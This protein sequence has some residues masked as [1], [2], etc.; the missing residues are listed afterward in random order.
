[1]NPFEQSSNVLVS[2]P[3]AIPPF[4]SEEIRALGFPV[5]A[6][7]EAGVETCGTLADCMRL[8]LCLRTAHRVLYQLVQFRATTPDELYARVSDLPWEDYIPP[9]GYLTV[10]SSVETDAIRDSRFANVRCKDAI[11]DRLR[12]RFGR[13]PDSGPLQS[14]AVVFLYWKGCQATLYLNTS[15]EPL[16]RRGYRKIPLGAPMQETLAAAVISATGWDRSSH[17]VNPMC[18]SG[19][20][21]IEAAWIGLN[22]APGLLRPNFAFM[23][24]NGFSDEAWQALRNAARRAAV[25]TLRGRLIATDVNPKA[26][27]SAQLNARTAGVEQY[28]EF[29]TCD[30]AETPV[31][32]GSGVVILNPEYGERMGELAALEPV[33]RGIGDYFKQRCL[34]YKGYVFTGNS[35]LA[36]RVGLR[37]RRRTVF[38]NSRIE[39]RLLEYELYGGT[40]R[41]FADQPVEPVMPG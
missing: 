40:R 26:I 18:G 24:L 15:G 13:R 31:P 32:E 35:D 41:Q 25:K 39:C 29:Q 8:N 5:R 10:D 1:M 21:A 20:L 11:V 23:H 22:R 34:G 12:R 9:D 27:Q 14:G 30:F 37:T 19:T 17:F 3:K 28:I 7:I 33:Y 2:C 36:K 16:S 38:F 4:L 6:E